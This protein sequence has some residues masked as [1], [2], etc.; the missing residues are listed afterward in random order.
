ASIGAI[1]DRATW[2]LFAGR[3]DT[4]GG[5]TFNR[6]KTMEPLD[7]HTVTGWRDALVGSFQ[8]AFNQIIA[9]APK[10]VGMVLVLVIGYLVARLLDKFVT[11]LD[12][13]L[14]LE[15]AA[16]RSGLSASMHRAGIDR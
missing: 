9:L 8:D 7:L 16:E 15:K 5:F 3:G 10:V 13:S 1:G 2:L 4:A 14:G 11:A 6:S 12:H